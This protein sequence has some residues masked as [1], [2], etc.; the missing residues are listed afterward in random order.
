[1]SP[2]DDLV[3]ASAAY[4]DFHVVGHCVC[5]NV[6]QL[7]QRQRHDVVL[8]MSETEWIAS[9]AGAARTQLF[10]L[11]LVVGVDVE[12]LVLPRNYMFVRS[13]VV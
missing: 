6:L 1:M 11:P 5:L 8:A 3:R 13:Y 9:G 12:E 2:K 10:V 7:F 4:F